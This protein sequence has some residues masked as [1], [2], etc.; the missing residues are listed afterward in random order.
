MGAWGLSAESLGVLK[1]QASAVL[2]H[3]SGCNRTGI[4]NC[5]EFL[6][7]SMTSAAGEDRQERSPR[8]LRHLDL[9]GLGRD[10]AGRTLSAPYLRLD[11][12][13]FEK[14]GKSPAQ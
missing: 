1:T 7:K 8:E 3:R 12:L 13:N 10:P 14:C 9:N 5:A 4:C 2:V 6:Q 11:P